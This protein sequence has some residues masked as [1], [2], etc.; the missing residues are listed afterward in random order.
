MWALDAADASNEATL[1]LS[2]TARSETN[3]ISPE[4]ILEFGSL[5]VS[6]LKVQIYI[7]HIDVLGMG[8][9]DMTELSDT[10]IIAGF[11]QWSSQ[12]EVREYYSYSP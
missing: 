3:S 7:G 5:S 4:Y 2:T 9:P 8:I 6:S 11:P 12:M 1:S 10:E